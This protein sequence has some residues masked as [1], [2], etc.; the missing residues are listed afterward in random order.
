MRSLLRQQEQ[1]Q[2]QAINKYNS[3]VRD[4]NRKLKQAVDAYNRGARAHN[5]NVRAHRQRLRNELSKMSRRSSTTTY[6][7]YTASVHTLQEAFVRVEAQVDAGA[8]GQAGA[9]LVDLSERE[10]ANSA[11]VLNALLADSS[12]EQEADATLRETSLTNEL[13]EISPDLDQ[14]WRGA[15]FALDPKNPDAARHFCASSREIVARLL[16]GE[17]PD[18]LVL[19]A[20]PNAPLTDQGTPTR[21]A[22]VRFLLQ[23]SE[24]PDEALEEF[25]ERDLENV[26]TLF[27]VFNDGTHGSAGHFNLY[28]LSTIK[29]RVEDAIKFLHGVIR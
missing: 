15:L 16:E 19:A 9:M 1:K 17:A 6:V 12:E 26:V 11:E 10:A 18:Q 3:A 13:A 8:L 24:I 14:R 7:R 28:Q 27:E 29:R 25:V 4:Y 23:R 2:R 22:R 21:R 5:A 20:L